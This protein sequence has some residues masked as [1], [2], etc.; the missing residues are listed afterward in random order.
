MI[1]HNYHAPE[2]GANGTLL[3]PVWGILLPEIIPCQ[4]CLYLDEYADAEIRNNKRVIYIFQ[5]LLASG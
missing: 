2:R 4:Y 3:L 1:G 5:G